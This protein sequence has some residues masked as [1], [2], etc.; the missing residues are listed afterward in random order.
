MKHSPDLVR[1]KCEDWGGLEV[2][3]S[4][5]ILDFLTPKLNT[6]PWLLFILKFKSVGILLLKSHGTRV[7]KQAFTRCNANLR[8]NWIQRYWIREPD[9]DCPVLQFQRK[10]FLY[11]SLLIGHW[12]LQLRCYF[13]QF[14]E[15]NKPP[16]VVIGFQTIFMT[17]H[18]HWYSLSRLLKDFNVW[19]F[20][21]I[22]GY[23]HI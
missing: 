11:T 9:T 19:K 17:S 21:I 4:P 14:L 5:S 22:H 23:F 8:R 16:I 1:P 7:S 2:D 6:V 13:I 12:H 20:P 3:E 18:K 10:N 15:K